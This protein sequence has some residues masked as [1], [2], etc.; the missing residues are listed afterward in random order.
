MI[1]WDLNP[2]PT[3]MDDPDVVSLDRKLNGKI[4]VHCA[5]GVKALS[6]LLRGAW[7]YGGSLFE[8]PDRVPMEITISRI[9]STTWTIRLSKHCL[10]YKSS[11]E[12]KYTP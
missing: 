11:W 4:H 3:Y 6:R 9:Q 5:N 12:F 8:T 7:V 2:Q 10:L 1:Q